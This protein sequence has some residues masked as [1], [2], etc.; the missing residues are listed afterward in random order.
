MQKF[1]ISC[2]HRYLR[3]SYVL[4]IDVRVAAGA[5]FGFRKLKFIHSNANLKES[6]AH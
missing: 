4:E 5:E 2:Y 6:E 1:I 3:E